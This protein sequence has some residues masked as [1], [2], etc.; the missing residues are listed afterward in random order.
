MLLP[1]KSQFGSLKPGAVGLMGRVALA[2][3]SHFQEKLELLLPPHPGKT[4]LW[5]FPIPKP[6]RWDPAGS[7]RELGL[8]FLGWL[9]PAAAPPGDLARGFFSIRAHKL[10]K[11]CSDS[12]F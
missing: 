5:T 4:S 10:L 9:L 8:G 2:T 7:S 12:G 11:N 1:R 6:G 3:T